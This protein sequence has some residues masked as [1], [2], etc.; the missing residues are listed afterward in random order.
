MK[1]NWLLNGWIAASMQVSGGSGR[2][3]TAVAGKALRMITIT[4][5][6]VREPF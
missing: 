6:A 2:A 5:M 3:A 1:T 4:Q